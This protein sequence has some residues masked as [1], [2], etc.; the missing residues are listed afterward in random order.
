MRR[1]GRGI[2]AWRDKIGR[3][4]AGGPAALLRDVVF[5]AMSAAHR[6]SAPNSLFHGFDQ[7]NAAYLQALSRSGTRS[8][9]GFRL[10]ECLCLIEAVPLINDHALGGAAPMI[11]TT[12][13]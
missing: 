12:F 6:V 9:I 1:C 8:S 2:C 13:P 7:I 10:V 5:A 3:E 4:T 11:A